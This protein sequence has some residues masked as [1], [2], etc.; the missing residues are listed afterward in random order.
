MAFKV[1]LDLDGKTFEV[2]KCL[3]EARQSFDRQGNPDSGV[4]G[5]KIGLVMAGTEEDVFDKWICD[6]LKHMD[7]EISFYIDD[8]TYKKLEFK[9]GFL[10]RLNESYHGENQP[11]ISSRDGLVDFNDVSQ[12]LDYQQ[13]QQYHK[14]TG[15][16]YL[17]YCLISAEKIKID[18]VEHDNHW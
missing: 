10:V 7:G 3:W 2:L 8:S 9:N 18:G 15:D 12:D 16:S 1:N 17:I 11:E 13:M 5:G 6:P 4:A 14:R